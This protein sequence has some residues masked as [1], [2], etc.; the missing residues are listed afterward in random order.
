VFYW[1]NALRTFATLVVVAVASC[2]K[3]SSPVGAL[4]CNLASASYDS[5]SLTVG[6]SSSLLGFIRGELG[7]QLAE[8]SSDDINNRIK[9][10]LNKGLAAAD[11]ADA[12]SIKGV[13]SVANGLEDDGIR[14][15]ELGGRFAA[16]GTMASKLL[17][18]ETLAAHLGSTF[19][20][21]D[22]ENPFSYLEDSFRVGQS[23]AV[24]SPAI[25]LASGEGDDFNKKQWA[26]SQTEFATALKTIQTMKDQKSQIV[27]AIVDT[28][29]DVDHPALQDVLLKKDGKV[30]GYNFVANND[31]PDDDQGHGTHCAGIIAGKKVTEEG[32]VGVAE[33]AGPSKIKIMP[34]KVLGADG[35]GSTANINKG[36]RWA[37]DHGADVI[38]MS[39]GGAV[40]FAELQ[41][42]EGAESKVIRDAVDRGTIIVVAAGNENCPLGGSCEQSSLGGLNTSTIEKYTVL[43]CS[44]NGTLCVGASDP[45][46]TVAEYSNYPS[47][48][49]NGVDPNGKD[50]GT[51]RSSPDIVAPGTAI[52]STYP[53]GEY[54]VLS[55]TSMATPFVAGLAAIFKLKANS[56]ALES[57]GTHQ[58]SFWTLLQSSAADLKVEKDATRSHVGQ[59][60]FN[61]Y[62]H[63]LKDLNDGTSE[64]QVPNLS[65]VEGPEPGTDY[66]APNLVNLICGG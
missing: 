22:G 2:N 33:A 61:Y 6:L 11:L 53:D 14:F 3:S 52:Y 63:R 18:N 54:K 27:V 28:G 58:R 46:V 43:P 45:D 62:A 64:A 44:Y 59:V 26:Y 48:S 9:D 15:F 40:P 56:K 39:L 16:A 19:D 24:D 13:T 37:I 25:S 66:N 60:D 36:I 21:A 47:K 5:S 7:N 23:A 12:I 4:L 34:V 55:G 35:S 20:L 8:P 41:S 31:N 10:S 38:S 30:V 29:V 65:E 49:T 51:L 17:R 57:G 32:M 50:K 42:G 1:Q